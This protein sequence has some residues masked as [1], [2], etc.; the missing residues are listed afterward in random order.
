MVCLGMGAMQLT[1]LFSL[2][3]QQDPATG[4]GLGQTATLLGV[5]KAPAVICGAIGSIWAGWVAVRRGASFP[6]VVG[7]ALILGAI[8]MIMASHDSLPVLIAM[9]MLFNLSITAPYA[10]V[11][12]VVIANTSA[13]E[14]GAATGLMA[15]LRALSQGIGAQVVAILLASSTV[16]TSSGTHYP[17]ATGYVRALAWM[18]FSAGLVLV[19]G[20]VL[21]RV[22]VREAKVTVVEQDPA[23]ASI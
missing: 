6:M 21:R 8:M 17:D 2:L 1:E 7:G 16:V 15:V 11:P 4:V 13:T 3:I 12:M 20:L 18:A 23:S 19:F 10:A 5:I 9:M 14:T 22:S